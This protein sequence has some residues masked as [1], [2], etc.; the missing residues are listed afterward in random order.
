MSP[1]AGCLRRTSPRSFRL[2]MAVNRIAAE[3]RRNVTG[4]QGER[5]GPPPL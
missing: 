3:H 4:K 1:S 2:D 5:G